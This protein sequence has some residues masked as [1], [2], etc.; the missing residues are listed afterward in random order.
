MQGGDLFSFLFPFWYIYIDFSPLC[1]TVGLGSDKMRL[2]SAELLGGAASQVPTPEEACN[3]GPGTGTGTVQIDAV[4]A[5][6][7]QRLDTPER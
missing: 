3:T 6:A 5:A 2:A 1:E 7:Q 4:L